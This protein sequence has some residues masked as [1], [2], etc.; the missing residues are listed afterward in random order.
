MHVPVTSRLSYVEFRPP[1][2]LG[3][4]VEAIGILA[5]PLSTPRRLWYRVPD[6]RARIM[7]PLGSER[8]TLLPPTFE[9]S[10]RKSPAP[11]AYAIVRFGP[12]ATGPL[13]LTH[14]VPS[15][16]SRGLGLGSP[17]GAEEALDTYTRLTARLRVLLAGRSPDPRAVNSRRA[18][19]RDP[20]APVG[21]L[22]RACEVSPRTLL[23]SMREASQCTIRTARTL[24]RLRHA[25][26][27]LRSD[28]SLPWTRAALGAGFYDQA[29]F[30][31]TFQRLV[32]LAP[33]Q[34]FEEG[35]HHFNDVFARAVQASG[36][37][38]LVAVGDPVHRGRRERH[39]LA[40]DG[41]R[42]PADEPT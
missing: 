14:A 27:L 6:A 35:H 18:L 11:N 19:S 24:E 29:H 10:T 20:Q 26:R 38:A 21:D 5:V 12:W 32:G 1:A 28:L 41:R 34:F 4:W 3:M 17:Q 13:Q 23:R 25:L 42:R 16:W 8:C 30:A 9:K 36:Y 15:A 2:D 7:L 40:R 33:T 37:P 22:A 39:H 31:R